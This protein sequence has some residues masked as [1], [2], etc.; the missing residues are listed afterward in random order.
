MSSATDNLR[1]L[2]SRGRRRFND[3][4]ARVRVVGVLNDGAS[5]PQMVEIAV[6]LLCSRH[7]RRLEYFTDQEV[8]INFEA[9]RAFTAR[10]EVFSPPV[11]AD[12]PRRWMPVHQIEI[13][14][15]QKVA[16]VIHKKWPLLV[17]EE[18]GTC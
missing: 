16:F 3:Y 10:T 2:W 1:S 18:E 8:A 5:G 6:R 7:G 14:H 15:P 4:I 13:S 12:V 11:R 9:K 17:V